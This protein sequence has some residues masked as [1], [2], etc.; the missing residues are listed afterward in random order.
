[1]KLIRVMR[2]SASI[3]VMLLAFGFLLAAC[4]TTETSNGVGDNSQPTEVERNVPGRISANV[5]ASLKNQNN[6]GAQTS[7]VFQKNASE[8]AGGFGA[9]ANIEEIREAVGRLEN[10]IVD[11]VLYLVIIDEL[12]R[13]E[14]LTLSN[15]QRSSRWVSVSSA[16][17]DFALEV[18]GNSVSS[19]RAE[20]AEDEFA[21]YEGM[22]LF[23]PPFV[24]S[25]SS[26][27][28]FDRS[29]SFIDDYEHA[30][31]DDV[32]SL[33][34]HW[35]ND[36]NRVR[37]VYSY[38]GG[39][40]SSSYQ[41][42]AVFSY[43]AVQQS[44][45]LVS[46]GVFDDDD[47]GSFDY[48]DEIRLRS[49]DDGA[50]LVI[51]N[52]FIVDDDFDTFEISYRARGFADDDGGFLEADWAWRGDGF[53]D[54]DRTREVF[55]SDAVSYFA[56]RDGSSWLTQQGNPSAWDAYSE[57]LSSLPS[58][59]DIGFDDDFSGMYS[60]AGIQVRPETELIAISGSPS[61]SDFIFLF[62]SSSA[63]DSFE[64]NPD[65]F[66]Q[67]EALIGIGFRQDTDSNQWEI[68]V[69][70]TAASAYVV[71]EIWNNTDGISYEAHGSA[72]TL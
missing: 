66:S 59:S 3:M 46:Y 62:N 40:Q 21:N 31:F 51:S 27:S 48:F 11:A 45:T 58:M 8:T 5:P 35:S 7:I 42:G 6:G 70:E 71:Y 34:L 30:D 64:S 9:S 55:S 14:S 56:V 15:T 2:G 29:F 65:S 54:R 47:F 22:E 41:G 32:F 26:L 19:G 24:Y 43:N 13:S 10:E 23:I 17:I 57:Q 72:V 53:A 16:M 63:A 4:D 33:D 12:I 18:V 69:F 37:G 1:M 52:Y 36:M 39:D 67:W 28:G 20:A 61:G 60:G 38:E 44:S 49:E 25:S 50:Y 68:E